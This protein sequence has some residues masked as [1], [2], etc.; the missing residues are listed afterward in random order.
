MA[1]HVYALVVG[2]DEYPDARHRLF[3]CVND[4]RGVSA[5]LEHHVPA[6][7]LSLKRLLKLK[8]NSWRNSSKVVSRLSLKK[9]LS[10]HFASA[11]FRSSSPLADP[12]AARLLRPGRRFRESCRCN[13]SECMER[14]RTK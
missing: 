12:L 2:I 11:A 10:V 9:S 14:A 6:E 3:G 1:G 8:T 13:S 5:F 4:A 7:R